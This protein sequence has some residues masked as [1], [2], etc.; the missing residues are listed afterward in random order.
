MQPVGGVGASWVYVLPC[1][2][3][4]GTFSA[5][6]C[7]AHRYAYNPFHRCSLL[8]HAC[9]C[10]TTFHLPP[11]ATSPLFCPKKKRPRSRSGQCW[12]KEVAHP[13]TSSLT[14]FPT[15]LVTLLYSLSCHPPRVQSSNQHKHTFPSEYPAP[16]Y[17]RVVPST[18]NHSSRP[19]PRVF[20]RQSCTTTSTT[21]HT[22]TTSHHVRTSTRAVR[23]P[24]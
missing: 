20:L 5:G 24:G 23:L 15:L 4:T 6:C 1:Q 11:S 13:A 22:H 2:L 10:S 17:Y 8:F 9:R 7:F 12:L 21:P 18:D 3:P 14:C 19:P 16:P